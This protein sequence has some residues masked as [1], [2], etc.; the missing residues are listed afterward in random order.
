MNKQLLTLPW[1]AWSRGQT[2][3]EKSVCP[4]THGTFARTE[5]IF[6]FS[7]LLEKY[8]CASI[9]VL[10][11]PRRGFENGD[12]CGLIT[13]KTTAPLKQAA[14]F[15]S[16]SQLVFWP[17]WVWPACKCSHKV[18]QIYWLRRGKLH[19]CSGRI[20]E[21][22]SWGMDNIHKE[23]GMNHLLCQTTVR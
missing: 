6:T 13:G 17:I 14:P 16:F 12:V 3:Y 22:M 4:S 11:F 10:H 21:G 5:L 20:F 7:F 8:K 23:N 18:T 2:D 9:L 15:W 1:C 19:G